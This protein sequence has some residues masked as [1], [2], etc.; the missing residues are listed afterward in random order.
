MSGIAGLLR[1]DRQP[2]SRPELER[3]ANALRAHGPDR[4]HV[5]I[6]GSIGFVHVLMRMTAEDQSDHQPY[7]GTSG[8]M[9]TADMRLDNRADMLARIGLAPRE[10]IAWPDS[11]V[12]LS[13][14]SRNRQIE[15]ATWSTESLP[16][17]SYQS[18]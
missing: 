16:V 18:R 11:R 7:R 12:L 9:I 6:D 4:S 15:V 5:V 14:S 13:R 3:V 17:R 2:A 10:A 1:F 8:S